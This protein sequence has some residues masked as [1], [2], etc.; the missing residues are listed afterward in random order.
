MM[1]KLT[2]FADYFQKIPAVFLVAIISVLGLILFLPEE[3]A[4]TLA[5]D[6]FRE[7]YRVYLGPAF[8]LT[9]SFLVARFFIFLKQGQT[10]RQNLKRM[11]KALHHL[12]PEEK[13]YLVFYIEGP[14]NTI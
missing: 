9:V 11:Q 7:K 8:L 1:N 5:A 3:T 4:K 10:K 2:G 12:T 14:K 6:E 13:G